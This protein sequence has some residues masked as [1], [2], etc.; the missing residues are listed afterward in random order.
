M[1]E[2]NNA[3]ADFGQAAHAI[4]QAVYDANGWF[5]FYSLHFVGDDDDPTS[6]TDREGELLGEI[7]PLLDQIEAFSDS[8]DQYASSQFKLLI[9]APQVGFPAPD[10]MPTADSGREVIPAGAKKV[11][12]S[13]NEAVD[14][15]KRSAMQ[16]LSRDSSGSPVF[17]LSRKTHSVI[18]AVDTLCTQFDALADEVVAESGKKPWVENRARIEA[19]EM[20]L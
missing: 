4:K 3:A 16:C 1:T 6:S 14:Q 9:P 18:A 12:E 11:S 7:Y 19:M 20:E 15:L 8:L 5:E 13:L 2:N 17:I 10:W